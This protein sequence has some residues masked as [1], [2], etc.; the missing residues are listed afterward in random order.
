MRID[1]RRVRG[2]SERLPHATWRKQAASGGL[3]AYVAGPG[4]QSCSLTG[5]GAC[6][7]AAPPVRPACLA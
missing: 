1:W 3:L 4:R 7:A 5:P 6:Q 2:R